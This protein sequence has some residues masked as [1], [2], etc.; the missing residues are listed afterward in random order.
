MRSAA[1][2]SCTSSSSRPTSRTASRTGVAPAASSTST[3][4][5]RALRAAAYAE[6]RGCPAS[7]PTR[8]ARATPELRLELPARPH[9]SGVGPRVITGGRHGDSGHAAA[10]GDDWSETLAA[11]ETVVVPA[12]IAGLRRSPVA[13]RARRH[14]VVPWRSAC[15]SATR[16]GQAA[17]S[18]YR[19]VGRCASR[20]VTPRDPR[21]RRG[22]CPPGGRGGPPPRGPRLAEVRQTEPDR[23]GDAHEHL[24]VVVLVGRGSGRPGRCPTARREPLDPQ[25]RLGVIGAIRALASPRH[26]DADHFT[27]RHRSRPPRRPDAHLPQTAEDRAA[28]GEQADRRADH[29]QGAGAPARATMIAAVPA[30]NRNGSSGTIAPQANAR[31]E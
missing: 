22:G 25:P 2:R 12:A 30:V 16:C 3:E 6:P 15:G 19:P 31:N 24:V 27:R 18:A 28:A 8:G 13:R 14:R 29:E 1:G 10:H 17:Q 20:H 4:S 11:R 7:G 23:P 9:R 21:S 26:P 5:L